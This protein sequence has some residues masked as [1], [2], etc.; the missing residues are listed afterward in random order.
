MAVVAL[1]TILEEILHFE[2]ITTDSRR[3]FPCLSV[4]NMDG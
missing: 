3:N 4:R 2:G 1:I